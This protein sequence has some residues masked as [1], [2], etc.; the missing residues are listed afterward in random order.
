MA[1]LM[2]IPKIH[3]LFDL[4]REDKI[5]RFNSKPPEFKAT[6][7]CHPWLGIKESQI[8]K[9]IIFRENICAI[10]LSYLTSDF[11][12]LKPFQLIYAAL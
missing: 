12:P 2:I 4:W 9:I 1:C 3:T 7:R 5:M 6:N 10:C 11:L 8:G